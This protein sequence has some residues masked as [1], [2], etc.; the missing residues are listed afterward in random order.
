MDQAQ[1]SGMP[2]CQALHEQ[3]LHVRDVR[4]AIREAV[5]PRPAQRKVILEQLAFL[6]GG[7]DGEDMSGRQSGSEEEGG[8]LDDEAHAGVIEEGH[9]PVETFRGF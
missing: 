8:E 9:V 2:L 4:A 6:A 1:P 7:V 3:C 5:V